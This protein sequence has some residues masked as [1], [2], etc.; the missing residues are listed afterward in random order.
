MHAAA[1][2]I[3]INVIQMVSGH[4]KQRGENQHIHLV[5]QFESSVQARRTDVVEKTCHTILQMYAE[6]AH[7]YMAEKKKHTAKLVKTKDAMERATLLSRSREID[8]NLENIRADA[9]M[10]YAQM[11]KL[12]TALDSK[13]S[14]FAADLAQPLALLEQD[15]PNQDR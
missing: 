12:L 10:V 4:L 3:A 6:Q 11:G 13:N 1:I 7:D 15:K 5:S 2:P 9:R 8:R 14:N